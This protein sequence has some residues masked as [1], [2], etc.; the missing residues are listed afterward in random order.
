VKGI[1]LWGNKNINIG[2]DTC[3]PNG[4]IKIYA[5]TQHIFACEFQCAHGVE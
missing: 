4:E 2:A 5:Q 3:R 1:L